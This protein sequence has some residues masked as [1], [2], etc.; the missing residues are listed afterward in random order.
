MNIS[1][2]NVM[3]IVGLFCAIASLAIGIDAG[4]DILLLGSVLVISGLLGA[5]MS[6]STVSLVVAIILSI[7]YVF[8]GRKFIKQKFL[9]ATTKTNIDNAV[10]RVGLVVKDISEDSAG[11]VKIDSEEWR[12][13][14]DGGIKA[15]EKV[16]V[17]S[18]EGVG[19]NVEKTAK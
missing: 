3:I 16:I 13:S 5:S 9:I 4:F 6:S 11:I 14:S 19:L 10:G 18:V 17:K 8:L 15:G 7:G 1:F 12:A 2:E